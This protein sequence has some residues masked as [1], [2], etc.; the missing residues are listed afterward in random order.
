MTD[1]NIIRA[2]VCMLPVVAALRC[3]CGAEVQGEH[4][5]RGHRPATTEEIQIAERIARRNACVEAE[6]IGWS[7]APH[8]QDR[9]LCARCR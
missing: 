4:V 3:V 9:D 7:V 6:R 1:P 5:V 2:P 8:G